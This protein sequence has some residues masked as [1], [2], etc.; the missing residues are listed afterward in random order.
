LIYLFRKVWNNINQ[1]AKKVNVFKSLIDSRG[2]MKDL[3]KLEQEVKE[4]IEKPKRYDYKI[5]E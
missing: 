2:V 4:F 1:I 5:D 3:K